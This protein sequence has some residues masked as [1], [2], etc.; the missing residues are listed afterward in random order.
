MSSINLKSLDLNLNEMP[1]RV[2]AIVHY[3]KEAPINLCL[4][5]YD[6]ERAP[7]LVS[8]LAQWIGVSSENVVLTCGADGGLDSV[9]RYCAS[10]RLKVLIP[11]G[12]YA[13]FV[14]FAERNDCEFKFYDLDFSDP[15]AIRSLLETHA[16]WA[17]VICNPNNPTG[18]VIKDLHTLVAFHKGLKI[19]DEAY[20]EFYPSAS[21]A[22]KVDE[23]SE[24]I[25]IRTFSKAFSGAG[26]RL[27]YLTLGKDIRDKVWPYLYPFPTSSISVE[28]GIKLLK[29]VEQMS[30]NVATIKARVCDIIKE[31]SL[32]CVPCIRSET[33]FFSIKCTSSD[34]L[35]AT[36]Q[37]L[38]AQG[39]RT[40]PFTEG[41]LLR[42]TV[43][44]IF[45]QDYLMNSIIRSYFAHAAQSEVNRVR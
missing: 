41:N 25:V 30:E 11:R 38:C 12:S 31:L 24:L 2:E 45:S 33:N 23:Y 17:I 6:Q 15:T 3:K 44:T 35:E 39:I 14:L 22:D 27:G 10:Q 34:H 32:N 7:V 5:K 21:L 37:N 42:I 29:D 40:T 16:D 1:D 28:L 8:H 18:T 19:I 9:F 13:G 43:S 4:E 20:I 36:F 26:L